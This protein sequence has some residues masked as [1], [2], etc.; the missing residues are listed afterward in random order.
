[1]T[2]REGV[3]TLQH[4]FKKKS[5]TDRSTIE[6]LPERGEGGGYS[7]QRTIGYGFQASL[8]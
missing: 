6:K 8:V 7:S 1:M 5:L 2:V 4:I 3:D